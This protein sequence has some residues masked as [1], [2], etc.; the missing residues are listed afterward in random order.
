MQR[1]DKPAWALSIA[2]AEEVEEAD[3]DDL[4]NFAQN[5]DFD[6]YVDDMEVRQAL[7]AVRNRINELADRT[8]EKVSKIQAKQEEQR[9]EGVAPLDLDK[10]NDNQWKKTFADEWNK[11][12]RG[13][14]TDRSNLSTSRSNAVEEADEDARSVGSRASHMSQGSHESQYDAAQRVLQTSRSL[15]STHSNRSIR[16]LMKKQ[17]AKGGLDSIAEE[18]EADFGPTTKPPQIQKYHKDDLSTEHADKH[19]AKQAKVDASNLPYLHRNPAV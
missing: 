10:L 1:P 12:N 16:E 15:R 19:A 4:L 3:V 11:A 18:G 7:Q 5:L 6:K 17:A 14:N 2:E 8:D 13:G 9:Q